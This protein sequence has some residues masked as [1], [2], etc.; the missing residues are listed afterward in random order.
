MPDTLPTD[1]DWRRHWDG[2]APLADDALVQVGR[3]VGGK[4]IDAAQMDRLVGAIEDALDLQAGDVL[5]D[6]CCGNG[7]ITVRLAQRCAA[8][9]GIDYSRELIAVAR[10]D[11]AGAN[12][13]YHQRSAEQ[14]GP[15]DFPPP[16]LNKVVMNQGLQ[17]F[18]EAM[19][20]GLLGNIEAFARGET[21]LVF[22]DVPDVARLTAFYDTPE[23]WAAFERARAAG[24]EAL[25]TWWSRDHLRGVLEDFG[26][27]VAFQVDPGRFT[28]HYRF[29]VL[30]TKG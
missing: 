13:T 18:D 20:R 4:P 25:G 9:V 15:G 30:A 10:R 26:Y 22:T 12:V 7:L 28:A 14:I 1:R 2:G 19:L 3:T 8:V 6:L 21:R 29:D 23:R 16:G 11:Y 17:Y 24:E 5:A 27:A